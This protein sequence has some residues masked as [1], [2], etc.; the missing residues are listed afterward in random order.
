MVTIVSPDTCKPVANECIISGHQSDLPTDLTVKVVATWKP[1]E[2]NT[3]EKEK[4]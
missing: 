1:K 3:K 4:F 2:V